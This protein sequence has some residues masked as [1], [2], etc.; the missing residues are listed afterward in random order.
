MSEPPAPA[1]PQRLLD[2]LRARTPARV[3]VGRAGASY[4]TPTQLALRADHASARDAVRAEVDLARD[5][6]ADLVRRFGLFEVS[7]RADS[8]E[9]YLMRPDLGRQ[10]T[11]AARDCVRGR[12]PP[13][14][15]LQVVVGDGL[16]A[17]AVTA[18]VPSLLPLLAERSARRG[19]RFGQVFF[20][21]H[22]RVGV[23]N[24]V[25][26][27]LDPAVVVLLIGE[28]PGLATAESLSA[29]L[30]F[31]PRPGDTDS[32]RNL[33]SNI[34]ARGVPPAE[35]A[36]RVLALAE[37]MRQAQASGVC[38]KEELTAQEQQARLPTAD[39]RALPAP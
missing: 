36:P 13:G 3:L 2:D 15:D 9:Q 37:R 35:A 6:G 8:K 33:V 31:R 7:T 21:R 25:G 5:L 39:R 23:L 10:L 20:V 11:D 4:R 18:Q 30:A 26:E 17:A 28:R 19:W 24:D 1:D 29:Y 14:A 16:S 12:C 32:R 22:C 38:V 34:H 27:L